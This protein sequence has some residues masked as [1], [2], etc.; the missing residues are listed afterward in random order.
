MIS[1]QEYLNKLAEQLKNAPNQTK[2]IEI[3]NI[4]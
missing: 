4:F 1:K 3:K 2:L